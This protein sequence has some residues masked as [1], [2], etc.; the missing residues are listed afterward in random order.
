MVWYAK[1]VTGREF[2]RM[3]FFY[4]I[5]RGKFAI[6]GLLQPSEIAIGGWQTYMYL[7][8]VSRF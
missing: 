6:Y 4:R 3:F 5:Y 8:K 1:S 2:E 7:A